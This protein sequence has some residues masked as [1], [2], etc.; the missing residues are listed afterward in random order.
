MGL[1]T[2]YFAAKIYLYFT[3]SIRLDVILNL[4]F[5]AFLLIPIPEQ[6]KSVKLLTFAK[7]FLSVVFAI[8]LL[9]HD[10]WFPAPLDAY[11]L[12]KQN[13]I[14]STEYIYSFLLRFYN[15][16]EIL[17]LVLILSF[18]VLVR[19]YRKIMTAGTVMLLIFP[20][21]ISPG[22]AKQKEIEKYLGS[23]YNSELTRLTHFKPPQGGSPDFDIII[24][25]IC[26]L[27]WDDLQELN[28]AEHPF[29][30]Q[31]DYVFTNFNSV[32]TYSNPSAIRLLN[33]NCG[34]R[35]HPD[36]YSGL[37][38]ECS[39]MESLRAE[40]D[41]IYFARNHNGKYGNFDDE[42]KRY[43]QLNVAPFVPAN[44]VAKKYMFDDSP[45]YDDYAVLE[46]WWSARQKLKSKTA[47]LYYNTVTLHDGS[48]WI[49]DKEWW[50]KDHREMYREF[51]S[52]LLDDLTKFFNL[53]ASSGRDAVIIVIGE[54]G[55]AVR[56]SAME[57][58]G[59]RDIPLPR[60]ATVP[61]GIKFFGKAYHD[62]QSGRNLVISKPVSYFALSYVLAEFMEQSPFKSDRYM[63]RNFIDSIPI[64]NFVS[65]N[66]DN[67]IVK[68]D[69]R[70]YLFGKDKKWIL[71]TE[72]EL[73]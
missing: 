45:V 12:L 48:H 17:I 68:K 13:G 55:R 70:Y 53:V 3:G 6:S 11:H 40:G 7:V 20:L 5:F 47:T 66:Q 41:T 33:A 22:A 28:M 46:Q 31:F 44:L 25:H 58:P 60:V 65:E 16:K 37:P 36:L 64:T 21:F 49:A 24:L 57:T 52:G 18:C 34:Q 59:L 38:Q 23:F 29:F 2:L 72:N 67:I 15:L 8:L 19:K 35:R 62:A 32:S 10:T 42:V 54:H 9:W 39:L 73:K 61:V 50:K 14:P 56:G 71:L 26:S 43:G 4:L 69:D 1:W 63:T 30:K 51:L 27:S